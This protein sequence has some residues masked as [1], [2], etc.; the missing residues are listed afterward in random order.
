[1]E[2]PFNLSLNAKYIIVNFSMIETIFLI[3]ML[4]F[5]IL[6]FRFNCLP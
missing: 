2:L 3:F 6:Y 4:F 5:P 1:M